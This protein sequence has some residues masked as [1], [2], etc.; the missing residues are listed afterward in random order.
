MFGTK[1]KTILN[2]RRMDITMSLDAAL[3]HLPSSGTISGAR[4]VWM[5]ALS[6]IQQNE[7]EKTWQVRQMSRIFGEA[8]YAL[9][10]WKPL[11]MPELLALKRYGMQASDYRDIAH[12]LTGIAKDTAVQHLYP[13]Y[14]KRV[15]D[16]F[17]EFGEGFSD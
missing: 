8:E 17:T 10:E 12:A 16:V 11:S 7:L 15:Q 13:D 2:G 4:R 6:I 9:D 1:N 5:D 14:T 3:R